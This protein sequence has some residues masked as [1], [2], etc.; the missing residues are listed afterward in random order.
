[1][2]RVCATISG[3][4][5][6]FLQLSE[7]VRKGWSMELSLLPQDPPLMVPRAAVRFR[8]PKNP[9]AQFAPPGFENTPIHYDINLLAPESE[10]RRVIAAMHAF[11]LR[12]PPSSASPDPAP[13]TPS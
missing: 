2:L 5:E 1:M 7:L 9:L 6:T 3:M 11:A 10:L 4:D 13:S 12:Y 8:N